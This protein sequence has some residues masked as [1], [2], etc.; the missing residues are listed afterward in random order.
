M[1]AYLWPY[2]LSMN[3]NWLKADDM[4]DSMYQFKKSDYTLTLIRELILLPS[5]LNKKRYRY[6]KRTID[7]LFSFCAIL[8]LFPLILPLLTILIKLNS[9]GPVF[10]LQKRNKRNGAVFY[11]LKFRTMFINDEAHIRSTNLND[12]RVTWVGKFLRHS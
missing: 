12:N 2:N 4:D 11:C 5:P 8:I 3:K 6:T 9:K 7:I 10:F 1:I